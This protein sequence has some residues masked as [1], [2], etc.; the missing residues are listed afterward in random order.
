MLGYLP[1]SRL[2]VKAACPS[3]IE[4]VLFHESREV[5]VH[6]LEDVGDAALGPDPKWLRF[7][8]NT[9]AL[10]CCNFRPSSPSPL[11]VVDVLFSL[12]IAFSSSNV[13]QLCTP[14]VKDF[15]DLQPALQL[16]TTRN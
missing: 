7:C 11:F 13:P 14:Q 5:R 12:Q 16:S 1:F 15:G 6:G 3:W 8:H 4:A 9:I 10:A 2:R